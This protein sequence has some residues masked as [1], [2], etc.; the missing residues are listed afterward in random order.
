[1]AIKDLLVAF[2]DD[3]G[4]RNA[5]KFGL[6]MAEKYGAALTGMYAYQPQSYGSSVKQWIP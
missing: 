2:N 6:Q 5:L 3:E 4:A 1:M